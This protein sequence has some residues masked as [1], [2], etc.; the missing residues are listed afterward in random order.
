MAGVL[1]GIRVLDLGRFIAGP[2]CGSLLGDLGA[3]VIRIERVGGG[4]DRATL[5]LSSDADA[6]AG[7]LA[8][9]RNKKSLTL[10]PAS[11]RG[12]EVMQRLIATADIVVINM[13]LDAIRKLDL[14][15]EAL[16]AIKPDI[17]L[18]HTSAFGT[19]GPYMDRVGF[20]GVGQAMSSGVYM[21]GDV[22]DP[23]RTVVCWVDVSTALFNAYGALA[24]VL[25]RKA[26]G[27]GQRVETNLLRSALNMTNSTIIEQALLKIDRVPTGNRAQSG[28]PSDLH[29]T[30][31][32]HVLIQVAG[33]TL[34]RRWCR[35]VGAEDWIDDPRFA[36]DQNRGDN[37]AIL[38]ARTAVW[39][40]ERTSAEALD[41]LAAA[42]I[43]AGPV[44]KPQEVLD[45]PHVQAA[46]L[47]HP[48]A[49][50]GLG[51]AIPVVEPGA[52][53]SGFDLMC[54]PPPTVGEHTD[55]ILTQLGYTKVQIAD[56]RDG[57]V[58]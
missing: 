10:D 21:S 47:Y 18:V 24:A 3:E 51:D 54:N 1:D 11:P 25:H 17:I 13:P 36:S 9:N 35:I 6:G 40:A 38:S 52:R 57:G 12:R 29:R 7:Y 8:F 27:E 28:G 22:D 41:Q 16:K 49:Y 45:D 50:P 39:M 34:F 56:L 14:D 31:D 26:T 4:E 2:M 20:D 19:D 53:F 48:I 37:N 15:Y 33:D 43:P 42:K 30:K 46:N 5:P 58:I 23:R 44:L 55:E 32:G